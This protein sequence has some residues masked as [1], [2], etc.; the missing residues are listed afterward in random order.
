ME[1]V[2][3]FVFL[4]ETDTVCRFM[5]PHHNEWCL[6]VI[7]GAF[8]H[9][10]SDSQ[11]HWNLMHNFDIFQR[12]RHSQRARYSSSPDATTSSVDTST[13]MSGLPTLV[14]IQGKLRKQVSKALS[15][16]CRSLSV[17][18]TKRHPVLERC[19][20]SQ[21]RQKKNEAQN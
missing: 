8:E 15:R 12:W 20:A 16:L 3:R 2:F 18:T 9:S 7:G 14:R 19:G 17:L 11:L 1:F 4:R 5:V 13:T 10:V 21:S 6:V